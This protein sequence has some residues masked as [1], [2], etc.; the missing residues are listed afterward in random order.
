MVEIEEVVTLFADSVKTS[1]FYF[2]S[3]YFNSEHILAS[4]V[5]ELSDELS[6]D[7]L[8][9]IDRLVQFMLRYSCTVTPE[10]QID[11]NWVSTKRIQTMQGN[12]FQM[13]GTDGALFCYFSWGKNI[14][15]TLTLDKGIFYRDCK[16][17]HQYTDPKA[18]YA[19]WKVTMCKWVDRMMLNWEG[20]ALKYIESGVFDPSQK[21][22]SLTPRLALC[23]DTLQFRNDL[24]T[25]IKDHLSPTASSHR[26]NRSGYELA[27]NCGRD[28]QVFVTLDFEAESPI[29]CD[30]TVDE[31]TEFNRMFSVKFIMEAGAFIVMH[32]LMDQI[33]SQEE[34]TKALLLSISRIWHHP[35]EFVAFGFKTNKHIDHVVELKQRVVMVEKEY[36]TCP[37]CMDK[38]CNWA[39]TACGHTLCSDCATKLQTV[40][41]R[42]KTKIEGNLKLFF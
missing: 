36:V 34:W 6:F 32:P 30:L 41:P 38:P 8:V 21:I 11:C 26:E 28:Y 33:M 40:C 29:C 19:L 35:A 12:S 39:Y 1:L 20:R 27:R 2:G 7:A 25:L 4:H 9:L 3:S 22:L 14:S 24:Q 5:V 42:C 10:D 31:R 17:L 23:T 37:I 13:R 16:N 15:R 18:N